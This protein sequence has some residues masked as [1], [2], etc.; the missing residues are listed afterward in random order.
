MKKMEIAK[1]NLRVKKDKEQLMVF[2]DNGLLIIR[3]RKDV[4]YKG[5]EVGSMYNKYQALIKDY[6]ELKSRFTN[7]GYSDIHLDIIIESSLEY[8]QRKINEKIKE[9]LL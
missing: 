8:K 3:H 9:V 2:D 1:R 6:N 7:L 5:I 4:I